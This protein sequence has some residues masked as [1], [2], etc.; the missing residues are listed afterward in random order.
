MGDSVCSSAPYSH[1]FFKQLALSQLLVLYA[2]KVRVHTVVGSQEGMV[3]V[4][5]YRG[6]ATVGNATRTFFEDLKEKEVSKDDWKRPFVVADEAAMTL[7]V[8][9]H[10]PK[11]DL[12]LRLE[13]YI[14][15]KQDKASELKVVRQMLLELR[16][17]PK[18]L[19]RVRNGLRPSV[20]HPDS[21]L[22]TRDKASIDVS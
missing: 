2:K 19:F 12:F 13:Y 18:E 22:V 7:L 6:A 17:E 4:N 1:F 9:S 8:I 14:L 11:A 16:G 21:P 20:A 5:E 10:I 3:K 15:E